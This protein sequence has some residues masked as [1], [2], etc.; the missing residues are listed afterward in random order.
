MKTWHFW[1]GQ[2][3]LHFHCPFEH[4]PMQP[5]R[6][7]SGRQG[8]TPVSFTHSWSGSEADPNLGESIF[9]KLVDLYRIPT[10]CKEL[11]ATLHG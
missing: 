8:A 10:M 6:I 11:S 3:F 4:R 2:L 9:M 7:G 1:V 5:L